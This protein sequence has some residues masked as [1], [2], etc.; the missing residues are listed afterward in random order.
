M[1]VN[2]S[3]NLQTATDGELLAAFAAEPHEDVFAEIVRRHSGR[4]YAICYRVLGHAQDAEDAAQAVFLTLSQKA[5]ALKDMRFL[6]AWLHHVARQ[7]A[8]DARK[9]AERRRQREEA[10]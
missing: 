5:A 3:I 4:V 10:A 2:L 7:V 6:D 8:L 1:S 9:M